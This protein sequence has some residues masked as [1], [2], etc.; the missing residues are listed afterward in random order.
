[1]GALRTK[2]MEQKYEKFRAEGSL[3]D[4]CNLCDKAK[5]IKKFKHWRVIN[6]LFPYNRIAKVHHIIIPKRH[7]AYEK[8]NRAEKKEYDLIKSTYI[9]KEYQLMTEATNKRK[10]IPEHFHIQL[11]VVKE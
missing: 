7:V 5:S 11:I 2:K 6:N 4:G 10:S 9:E 8:L 1:M 3:A